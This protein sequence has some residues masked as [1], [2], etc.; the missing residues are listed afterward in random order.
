MIQVAKGTGAGNCFNTA[1]RSGRRRRMGWLVLPFS[2]SMNHMPKEHKQHTL[3]EPCCGTSLPSSWQLQTDTEAFKQIILLFNRP[4]YKH[5]IQYS[6]QH[7][8]CN[9]VGFFRN[10]SNQKSKWLWSPDSHLTA[11]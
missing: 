7:F 6:Y 1:A 9:L 3:H 11:I 8:N 10:V 5:A 4:V 2:D